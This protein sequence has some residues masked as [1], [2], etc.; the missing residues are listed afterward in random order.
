MKHILG[1]SA[2]IILFLISASAALGATTLFYDNAETGFLNSSWIIHTPVPEY[3]DY[4]TD[5]YHDGI[6]GIGG[7][8]SNSLYMIDSVSPD[9][10]HSISLS[11]WF[12]LDSGFSYNPEYQSVALNQIRFVTHTDGGDIFDYCNYYNATDAP[13]DC[14]FGTVGNGWHF[15]QILFDKIANTTY[16][17]VD[18]TLVGDAPGSLVPYDTN[19]TVVDGNSEEPAFFPVF[20]DEYNITDLE[21]VE[22][23]T[24]SFQ[25]VTGCRYNSTQLR[26]V[27]YQDAN[28]CGTTE[29]LPVDPENGTIQSV[30]CYDPC[31]ENWLDLSTFGDCRANDTYLYNALYV[32]EYACG[33]TVDIPTEPL[34]GSVTSLYCDFCVE[35]WSLRTTNLT[36]CRS[37]DTRLVRLS[38]A[39]DSLCNPQNVSLIPVDNG[40]VESVACAYAPVGGDGYLIIHT[41]P[42]TFHLSN[43]T[44]RYSIESNTLE[45]VECQMYI[46]DNIWGGSWDYKENP[47]TIEL[48]LSW[49]SAYPGLHYWWV[50]CAAYDIKA[51]GNPAGTFND[52][53][54]FSNQR[55]ENFFEYAYVPAPLK[56]STSISPLMIVAILMIATLLAVGIGMDSVRRMRR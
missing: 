28:A 32:D 22:N 17:Y 9:I 37:N 44:F 6:K 48:N 18:D 40:T 7:S 51:P 11:F 10:T 21:C 3:Q 56:D 8:L 49:F 15:Y 1:V 55:L 13:I 45:P 14:S 2:F 25:N 23:W 26:L 43:G 41:T 50:A 38:Y 4:A 20:I 47:V 36:A 16:V 19:F 34:N 12:Y 42:A 31:F 54:W 24:I 35:A 27:T 39:D 33:T 30:E 5:Y 53:G 29:T 52:T 46:D